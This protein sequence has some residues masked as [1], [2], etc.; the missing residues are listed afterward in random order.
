MRAT[1]HQLRVFQQVAA[2]MSYTEAASLL[3]LTQPA[4]SIQIKQLETNL[5]WTCRCWK[6]S[7]KNFF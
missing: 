3:R 1:L 5:V 6:K 2:V 4:V 7:G